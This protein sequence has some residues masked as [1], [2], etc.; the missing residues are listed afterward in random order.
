MKS[1][2][3][4]TRILVGFMVAILLTV[5]L[6]VVSILGISTVGESV[7]EMYDGPYAA[8]KLMDGI[9]IS[10]QEVSKNVYVMMATTDKDEVNRLKAEIDDRNALIMEN[11]GTLKEMYPANA[12]LMDEFAS[13][14]TSAAPVFE[15]IY[16]TQLIDDNA[17][18]L[19]LVTNQ[20]QPA[21]TKALESTTKLGDVVAKQAANDLDVAQKT[22]NQNMIFVIILLGV[23]VIVSVIL[24]I[25]ITRSVKK[26]VAECV[27][28]T[29]QIAKGNLDV[30]VKYTSKDELG[31][32]SDNVRSMIGTLKLY[33]GE[34][35][36]ILQAIA[37]GNLNVEKKENYM[38][39][40]E[41]IGTSLERILSS[42]NG[43]FEGMDQSAGQVAI[44]AN[45][46]SRGAQ[47]LAQ[48]ATEQ[49]SSVQELS[50]SIAH[51]NEQIQS[52]AKNAKHTQEL[53]E[54]TAGLVST[55]NGHMDD[56][57]A[58]MH[59][60]DTSSAEIAKIIK[61]IDDISFQ[62]N[63]LALNA[64][65]E[66]ARAG[67]AGKGF[68]VV[69]DEVRNLAT[70][71]AEAAKETS[72]LIEGSVEKVQIGNKK[73]META[74]VLKAVVE[75]AQKINANI[76]E[77]TVASEEQ[78]HSVNEINLGVEQIS[79]VVQTNSATAEESAA[80]SEELSGQA[81]MMKQML[82]RFQLKNRKA[83]TIDMF[84]VEESSSSLDGF[85]L[86]GTDK[87]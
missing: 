52:N 23:E 65:V 87:Y 50:A 77:I 83:D 67:D 39:N 24:A 43:T 61:V 16:E 40:F 45:E 37:D 53:I 80:A 82:A 22:T 21:L 17:T 63:I 4:G 36:Y 41:E 27:E 86:S 2:K 68:A 9:E 12:D 29:T 33:I 47:A 72:A 79:T 48:G 25:T 81:D 26:P 56:M 64:A 59:D 62:T 10:V 8:Q 18:T 73:A 51:V 71:S 15:Q 66:A 28:A 11:L 34:I 84:A 14:V 69:A 76:E 55:C 60:I 13:I 38:G 1:M 32:L 3:I 74:D 42:L 31:T 49:S 78:A 30:D 54:E 46:V 5:A 20:F 7:H 44:G 85:D 6:G 70:K 75:N 57:L 58:S 19:D 35:S